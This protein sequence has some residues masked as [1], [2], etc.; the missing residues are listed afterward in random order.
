MTRIAFCAF[1]ARVARYSLA[2]L[3]ACKRSSWQR[4]KL[5]SAFKPGVALYQFGL[6]TALKQQ[7]HGPFAKVEAKRPSAR[8]PPDKS[9]IF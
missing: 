5:K 4:I 9:P 8:Y 3:C 6:S 2:C 7:A 1:P